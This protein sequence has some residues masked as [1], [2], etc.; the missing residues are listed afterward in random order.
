MY[1]SSFSKKNI[2][3]REYSRYT[4]SKMMKG[5][6]WV[7]NKKNYPSLCN[8]ISILRII[9]LTI[10]LLPFFENIS[11][12]SPEILKQRDLFLFL[13]FRR[14]SMFFRS[15]TWRNSKRIC[16]IK[17]LL[18]ELQIQSVIFPLEWLLLEENLSWH[19]ATFLLYH[20]EYWATT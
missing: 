15:F 9:C 13:V 10:K 1:S 3:K 18:L 14:I 6:R 5:Q 7:M 2:K 20:I 16:L 19:L 8:P 11:M 4:L 17:A 12:P